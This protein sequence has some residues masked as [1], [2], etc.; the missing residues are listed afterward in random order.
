MHGQDER[1]DLAGSRW[2]KRKDNPFELP[3][4]GHSTIIVDV[5]MCAHR[6]LGIRRKVHLY[7]PPDL[8]DHKGVTIWCVPM[9]FRAGNSKAVVLDTECLNPIRLFSK[10]PS[11]N[12]SRRPEHHCT[13]PMSG[14]QD[15]A[16]KRKAAFRLLIFVSPLATLRFLLCLA[17]PY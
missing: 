3:S 16:G 10:S 11:W 15:K 4:C 5:R 13:V 1:K 6:F 8:H 2:A 9:V 12:F 7:R 14:D 17:L